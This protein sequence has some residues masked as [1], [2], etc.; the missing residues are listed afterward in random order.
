[1]SASEQTANVLTMPTAERS[2]DEL[3]RVIVFASRHPLNDLD[4]AT[5]ET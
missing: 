5:T 4:E 2:L 1:M 3:G